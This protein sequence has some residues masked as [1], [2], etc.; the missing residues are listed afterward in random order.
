MYYFMVISRLSHGGTEENYEDAGI[1][2]KIRTRQ[3]P[4]KIQS[5][6]TSVSVLGANLI[7]YS[8]DLGLWLLNAHFNM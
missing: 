4:N 7:P 5:L 8:E 2:A 1:Q 6:P 3:F